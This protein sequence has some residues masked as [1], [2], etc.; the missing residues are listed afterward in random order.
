MTKFLCV[1]K[2]LKAA[3]C[4]RLIRCLI[5]VSLLS[6]WKQNQNTERAGVLGE[7]DLQH[8]CGWMKLDIKTH[9]SARLARSSVKVN[10]LFIA[11]A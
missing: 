3:A 5:Y 7:Q 1:V 11:R 8:R 6:Q 10:L 2:Q 4:D 9:I